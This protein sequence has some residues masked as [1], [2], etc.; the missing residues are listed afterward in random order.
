MLTGILEFE[1]RT[2]IDPSGKLKIE[3][4]ENKYGIRTSVDINRS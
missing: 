3:V 2:E 1:I 4:N